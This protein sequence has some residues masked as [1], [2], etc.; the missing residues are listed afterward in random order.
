MK[1]I[2]D[3][4]GS[5]DTTINSNT[6][7]KGERTFGDDTWAVGINTLMTLAAITVFAQSKVD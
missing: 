4:G 7:L 2:S 3:R 5:E 1:E 6:E